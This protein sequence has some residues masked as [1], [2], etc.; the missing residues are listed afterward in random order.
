MNFYGLAM[1]SIM[2]LAVGLGHVLVIKWEYYW[3]TKSWI[4]LL[5]IGSLLVIISILVDNILLSGG[6][7][8][9]G[10]TLLWGVHEL[11]R[12]KKRVEKGWFPRNLKRRT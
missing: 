12:Q 8:I 4:G 6:L 1:G 10:A 5:A 11:F 3:G 9:L 7:G 2:I